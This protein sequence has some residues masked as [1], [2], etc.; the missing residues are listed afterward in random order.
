MRSRLRRPTAARTASISP[1]TRLTAQVDDLEA[2]RKA[3]GYGPID[4]V[5]ES[6]GTRLAMIYAWRYPKSIH[7]SVMIGVN[8]PG[9]FLWSPT[10]TDSLIHTYAS[11]CARDTFLPQP[12]QRPRGLDPADCRPRARPVLVP[13]DRQGQRPDR[14]LLRP[15][16]VHADAQ[17]LSA[18]MT[19]DSWLSAANGDA[20]G[21]WFLSLM[22]RVAFPESFVWGELAAVARADTLAPRSGTSRPARTAATRSSATPEP[23]SST[24]EAAWSTPGRRPRARTST[25]PCETRTSTPAGRRA[26]R[27]R[28]P[29]G[30][31][32]P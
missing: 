19:I 26:T 16:G 9:H 28:D 1:A 4:L 2:A 31:R 20:S 25:R 22:S 14:V 11:L 21:L 13:A 5:S 29:R 10:T 24:A 18:P 7:R 27:L 23:S 12:H 8:P 15:D 3:L 17:P 6:A 30:Q 32:D